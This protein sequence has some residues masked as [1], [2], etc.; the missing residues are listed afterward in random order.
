MFFPNKNNVSALEPFDGTIEE[1]LLRRDCSDKM[2]EKAL[3][4]EPTISQVLRLLFNF[5]KLHPQN[6]KNF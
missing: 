2:L 4:R 3:K 6:K 5:Y 1:N